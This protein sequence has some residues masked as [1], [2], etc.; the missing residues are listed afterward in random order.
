MSKAK[1][2]LV[3]LEDAD[4]NQFVLDNQEAFKYGATQ[5]FGL[6]DDH[7][8]EDGEIISRDTI[9]RAIDKEN[10]ETYRIVCDGK[11][12]GGVAIRIDK[13]ALQGNL[14]LLFVS[15]LVHNR[16]IGQ[17]AWR[18]IEEMHPEVKTWETITPYFEKRNIHFY[19]NRCGFHIVEFFNNHHP[20]PNDP[21]TSRDQKDNNGML[22]FQKVMENQTQV[23][24]VKATELLRGSRSWDGTEMP[25]YPVG[26]PELVAMRY[27][28]AAGEK[29]GW[30]HHEVMNYG[31]LAQGELTIVDVD[32]NE[33]VFRTG[34]ALIEM[35]GTIH[36]GE[37]R[38]TEPV[39][40]YMFYV[41][42]Q[43]LPLSVPH[44]E[45]G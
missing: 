22:R 5:E 4:R 16:G 20:D 45:I 7:F 18:A 34:E 39:V 17:A 30:H 24:G 26:R 32:G 44:P 21:E 6:R 11:V 2:T 37:N 31:F 10:A 23:K 13:E 27:E 28:F 9:E 42:Q 19:V 40:L 35:V 1:V 36:R 33:K 41:S 38:G 25:D 14:D 12:V 15:P 43:G 3:P 8:E 29:L